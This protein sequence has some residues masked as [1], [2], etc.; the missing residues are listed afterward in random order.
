MLVA[1]SGTAG[2]RIRGLEV[3]Y[4]TGESTVTQQFDYDFV[5]CGT[6]NS[7]EIFCNADAP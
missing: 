3:A 2:S 7:L 4:S 6:N 5:N 1:T